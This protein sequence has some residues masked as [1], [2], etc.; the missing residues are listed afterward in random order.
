VDQTNDAGVQ[1]KLVEHK[2]EETS[3]CEHC[4]MT[5]VNAPPQYCIPVRNVDGRGRINPDVELQVPTSEAKK[6]KLG[7][8]HYD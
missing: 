7:G 4:G 1:T 3:T 5:K 2:P 6:E 8:D